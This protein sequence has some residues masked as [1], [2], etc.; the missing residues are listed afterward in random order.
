MPVEDKPVQE[1]NI[2]NGKPWGCYNR[3]DFKP[4]YMVKLQIIIIP[5]LGKLLSWIGVYKMVK[6]E[7]TNSMECVTGARGGEPKCH[8]CFRR[9]N[10]EVPL[11]NKDDTQ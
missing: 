1:R 9:V 5:V 4:W 2:D 7:F 10:K 6:H 3:P 8:D 11:I